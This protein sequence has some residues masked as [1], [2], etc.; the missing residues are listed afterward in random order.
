MEKKKQK[1]NTGKTCQRR[2]LSLLKKDAKRARTHRWLCSMT[3]RPSNNCAK[4]KWS[5]IVQIQCVCVCIV[6]VKSPQMT[7]V[8]PVLLLLCTNYQKLCAR[9]LSWENLHFVTSQRALL[10][11]AQWLLKS[12]SLCKQRAN[13]TIS[14]NLQRLF[15]FSCCLFG[16]L[17]LAVGV[18][19][20]IA[21]RSW[22]LR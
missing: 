19:R 13:S 5:H 1:L 16:L 9:N 12:L 2:N 15:S 7:K 17:L 4:F 11:P 6:F 10:H 18:Q 22:K 21:V 14:A 20:S 8:L 3:T